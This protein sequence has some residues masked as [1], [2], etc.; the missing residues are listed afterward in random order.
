[1]VPYILVGMFAAFETAK[2]RAINKKGSNIRASHR[3]P[4]RR[5]YQASALLLRRHDATDVL[6]C[7]LMVSV[8]DEFRNAQRRQADLPHASE[9]RVMFYAEPTRAD[10][11]QAGRLLGHSTQLGYRRIYKGYIREHRAIAGSR[12]TRS[13]VHQEL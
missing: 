8:L 1:M 10:A 6:V 13:P 4:P 3:S 2:L 12:S 7:G 11:G 5:A 9:R